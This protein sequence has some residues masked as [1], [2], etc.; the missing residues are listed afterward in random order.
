MK[1]NWDEEVDLLVVGSGGGGMTAA[2]VAKS[3]GLDVLVIEKTEFYGGSTAR[4]GG[5][6]WI[7]DNH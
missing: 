3:L 1:T 2:L 6:L 4:S 5:A 7:P